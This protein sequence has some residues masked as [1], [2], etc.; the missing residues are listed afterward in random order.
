MKN[1]GTS[2]RAFLSTGCAAMAGAVIGAEEQFVAP[3]GIPLKQEPLAFDFDALEPHLDAT[4]LKLHH[5]RHHTEILHNLQSM[6]RRI[7]LDVGSVSSLMPN[8][9]GMVLPTDPRRTVVKMGGPPETLPTE[10][11]K[12]LRLYGGAHVNHTAFWRFLTPPGTGP[13]GPEGRVAQAI[14]R[15][16]GTVDDFKAA[17]TDAALKHFGSGWAFL[18]YRPD[19]KLVI[20]TLKNEDNPLMKEFVKPEQQGRFIL[21]LDLWEH[22]YYLKY[23]NDRKKYIDAWW[24]VVN[25]NFVARSYAVVT[26]KARV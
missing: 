7:H 2:R 20:T 15:D 25:W 23:R 24:N 18:V 6:L 3:L 14:E 1:A 22:S 9:R 26:A 13:A 17:F 16:F 19:G 12:A 21:C 4:T 11:Q 10:M 5:G 8:I